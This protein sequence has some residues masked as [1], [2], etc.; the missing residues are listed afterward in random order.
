MWSGAIAPRQPMHL[1]VLEGN[2]AA[3]GFYRAQ[4]GVEADRR[5]E[6]EGGMQIVSLRY[7]LPALP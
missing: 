6:H 3:R 2:A 4:G 7:T 1:W 5:V